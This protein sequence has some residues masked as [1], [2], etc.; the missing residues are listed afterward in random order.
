LEFP[1]KGL[2]N[3]ATA[4]LCAA[5][6]SACTPVE[7][8]E[9]AP[10]PTH[11]AVAPPTEVTT[12]PAVPEPQPQKKSKPR[13]AIKID[14]DPRRLIGLDVKSLTGLL[15]TPGFTRRDP[16]AQ[17]WRYRDKGCILDLFLYE[18]PKHK[19]T[20]VVRHFEARSLSKTNMT[21]R[22]CLRALL[23]ARARPQSG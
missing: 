10:A 11:E 8:D 21:A 23:I 9:F 20:S 18:T 13:V 7:T 12:E 1:V 17:L 3:L 5:V 15:G 6:L 4:G 14:D 19:S 2:V 22:S 16:P